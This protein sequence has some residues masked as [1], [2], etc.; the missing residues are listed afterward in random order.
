MS[1]TGSSY[2]SVSIHLCVNSSQAI[3]TDITHSDHV[4]WGLLFFLVMEIWKF[5]IVLIQ[6]V[7]HCTWPYNLSR[8]QWRTDVMSSMQSF[9]SSEAEGTSS[10]SLMSQIQRITARSLRWSH[11]SSGSFGSHVSL[12]WSIAEQTHASYTLPQSWVRGVWGLGWA[13]VSLTFT[14]PHS[15]WQQRHCHS[16]HQ[17]TAYHQG[18]RKWFPHQAWCRQHIVCVFDQSLSYATAHLVVSA[19][20]TT[21]NSTGGTCH[22]S[23]G[24]PGHHQRPGTWS[25]S[26]WKRSPL[27][28]MP[29]FH[30]LSLQVPSSCV[31]AMSTRSSA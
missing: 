19:D 2:I 28:S 7:A 31:S 8:W 22:I 13:R 6:D 1:N 14:R 27:L 10:L 15:I 17:S 24:H 5:V 29:A 9:C 12:P 4:L 23:G 21:A 25:S 30:A 20:T 3:L 26:C 11:H 18:S 16:L